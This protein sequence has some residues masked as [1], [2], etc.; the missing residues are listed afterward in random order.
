L[1]SAAAIRDALKG[2]AEWKSTAPWL[3]EALPPYSMKIIESCRA[4][5]RLAMKTEELWLLLQGLLLRSTP[6]SLERCAGMEEGFAGLFLKHWRKASSLDDFLGRCV[7]ARYPKS[8]LQRQVLW[9]LLGLDRWQNKA[10][11][12]MGPSYIRLLGATERGL[13]LVRDMRRRAS[14]PVITHLTRQGPKFQFR[15]DH[16]LFFQP[17]EKAVRLIQSKTLA[18]FEFK[19]ATLWELLIPGGQKD[20]E[21]RQIPLLPNSRCNPP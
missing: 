5:G 6:E 21:E 4:S 12:R 19:A 10:L 2:G 3:S 11:Q 14:L 1:A 17:S 13:G 9:L 20:H 7:S 18:E 16:E 15:S 8:R